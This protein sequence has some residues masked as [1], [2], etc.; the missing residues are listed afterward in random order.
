MRQ[1]KHLSFTLLCFFGG[2]IIDKKKYSGTDLHLWATVHILLPC[3]YCRCGGHSVPA[4]RQ[5][6]SSCSMKQHHVDCGCLS[7]LGSHKQAA[8]YCFQMSC[9]TSPPPKAV[10][11]LLFFLLLCFS[12]YSVTCFS[13]S[14][15]QLVCDTCLFM[16]AVQR[17]T[18]GVT[19]L[20]LFLSFFLLLQS[21]FFF[22]PAVSLLVF[23]LSVPS[24]LIQTGPIILSVP[25]ESIGRGMSR[26]F[27]KS[28]P[29]P[30]QSDHSHTL[31]QTMKLKYP[32][33]ENSKIKKMKSFEQKFFILQLGNKK[34]KKFSQ[35]FCCES[36]RKYL[37][38]QR[39]SGQ[40]ECVSVF[41]YNCVY[42]EGRRET[43]DGASAAGA[44][45]FCPALP[46]TLWGSVLDRGPGP[47]L[48]HAAP[49]QPLQSADSHWHYIS[50]GETQ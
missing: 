16:A 33:E 36:V 31:F 4:L 8:G 1:K 14:G 28:L 30:R 19:S 3:Y 38:L 10:P 46:C 15:V 18:S 44:S 9:N 41:V 29:H 23:A 48:R 12:Q 11:C 47:S 2:E 21:L 26:L 49:L 17:K 37:W 34:K 35:L 20:F 7:V 24:L 5:L 39:L 25:A 6:R 22:L 42:V 50:W 27:R 43:G 32:L 45:W 40:P 13:E